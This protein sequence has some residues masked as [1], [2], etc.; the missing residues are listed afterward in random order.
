MRNIV[1]WLAVAGVIAF[2]VSAG[3]AHADTPVSTPADTSS[4]CTALFASAANGAPAANTTPGQFCNLIGNQAKNADLFSFDYGVPHSPALMLAGLS[5][6]KITP[7]S[8]LKPFVLSL[9]GLLGS[10]STTTSAAADFAP[11]W[12]LGDNNSGDAVDY[13]NLGSGHYWNRVWFRTRVS[14]AVNKG[15]DGGSDPT[16]ATPSRA[17][18]G[19]S[20]SLLDNSDP[21]WARTGADG[22]IPHWLACV[23][24]NV[25]AYLPA[26]PTFKPLND[27]TSEVNALRE[28]TT[29]WDLD[30]PSFENNAKVQHVLGQLKSNIAVVFGDTWTPPSDWNNKTERDGILDKL[31]AQVKD[32]VNAIETSKLWTSA[33]SDAATAIQNCSKEASDIAQ[34][35]ADLQ[36]G[37][38]VVWRGPNGGKDWTNFND[39]NPAM[40]LAG[41]VPLDF[42]QS[43]TCEST[44]TG[45]A[46]SELSCWT[47][48]GSAR[49]SHGEFD[50][51]GNA[52]TPQFKADVAEGWIGIERVDSRSKFGAYLGY[53]DQHAAESADKAFSKSGTR[54]LFSGAY[55]LSDVY[56]GLWVVGSYG[57]ANGTVSTLNDKVALLTL[58]FGPPD[59][60]SGFV[61]K[62]NS[63]AAKPAGP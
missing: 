60:S 22:K 39:P 37:A 11:A 46:R 63:A 43:G 21:V 9:P 25:K 8:S 41:R 33:T 7:A 55:S 45:G 10:S 15:D 35:G 49:Y 32:R 53:T 58:T 40:W 38:G 52:A 23:Q 47:F 42:D 24:Q 19:L 36:I 1:N 16:K 54:W 26:D 27:I 12:A 28:P 56:K 14:V 62:T 5:T 29:G 18:I 17:A 50:A 57:A 30:G 61:D 13:A 44:T 51:T 2:A 59:T 31:L 4:D 34:H 20:F 3:S 48:G 6:D